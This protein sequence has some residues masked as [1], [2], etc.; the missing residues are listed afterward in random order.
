MTTYKFYSDIIVMVE[1]NSKGTFVFYSKNDLDF[2]LAT[3]RADFLLLIS[4]TPVKNNSR[5]IKIYNTL[6]DIR[7]LS[8]DTNSNPRYV[9][10][11]VRN[12]LSLLGKRS[13]P[14]FRITL[15]G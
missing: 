11:L 8:K 7:D 14:N 12:I 13:F 3:L 1:V 10:N 15:K 5:Y 6:L 2:I 9:I 4:Q